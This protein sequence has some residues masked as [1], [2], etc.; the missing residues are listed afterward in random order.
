[1]KKRNAALADVSV[2]A[3][4]T[5]IIDTHIYLFQISIFLHACYVCVYWFLALPP[6]VSTP[7]SSSRLTAIPTINYMAPEAT[8]VNTYTFSRTFF[9]V[10]SYQDVH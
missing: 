5:V 10:P 3:E 6:P 9:N 7:F 4:A 8:V 2:V 1:M